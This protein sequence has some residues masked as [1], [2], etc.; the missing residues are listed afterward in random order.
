MAQPLEKP[1][2]RATRSGDDGVIRFLRPWGLDLRNADN[3]TI[4][5]LVIHSFPYAQIGFDGTDGTTVKG[6]WLGI[7]PDG[8]VS[9]RKS[10]EDRMIG[11]SLINSAINLIGGPD[12]DKNVISGTEIGLVADGQGRERQPHLRQL[13][14]HDHRRPRRAGQQRD[15]HPA[16]RADEPRRPRHG[17]EPDHRQ[18]RA[19]QRRGLL[20]H[21]PPR[22]Q[23]N[24]HLG[25][26]RRP[27]RRGTGRVAHGRAARARSRHLRPRLARD[28][29]RRHRRRPSSTSSPATTS[30]SSSTAARTARRSRPTSSAP[31]T[32][33]RPRPP[34][35]ATATASASS[36]T[37]SA[38]PRGT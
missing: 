4:R 10:T 26:L 31:S 8:S 20:R 19:R 37:A 18:R 24:R 22:R 1:K 28:R 27:Q 33:A 14:R 6:N 25:Q 13:H 15:R 29:D 36:P 30:A 21:Q 9:A 35:R 34:D 3:S 16:H 5:G 12:A 32:A 11:L 38:R 2:A 7:K 23:G 17:A